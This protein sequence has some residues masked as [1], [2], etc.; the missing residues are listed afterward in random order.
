MIEAYEKLI[1]DKVVSS[2]VANEIITKYKLKLREHGE[3]IRKKGVDPEE[4][5]QWQWK[6][7]I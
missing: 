3:Y 6:R 1:K 7:N 5:E 2:S 4:I